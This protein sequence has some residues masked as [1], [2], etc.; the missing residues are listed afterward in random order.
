[1]G[2]ASA[3][4]S[5]LFGSIVAFSD[6]EMKLVTGVGAAVIVAF[7]LLYKELFYIALDERAARL[8]GVPVGR[9][10]FVFTLLTAAAVAVAARTVGAL[11]ASSMMVVPVAC[12]M[13]LETSYKR[14]VVYSVCFAEAFT[15]LGLYVSFYARLKPGSAV[16]LLGVL[17]F[18]A[19]LIIKN[20]R[21][22]FRKL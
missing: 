3:F 16:V 4:G 1:V 19:I 21:F 10:N 2:N 14:T 11:M 8:A 13:Q 22:H 15:A 18:V 12:A 17:C 20:L 6:F 7:L 5:F 9:V